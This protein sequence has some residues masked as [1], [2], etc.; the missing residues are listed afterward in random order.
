MTKIKIHMEWNQPN[1]KWL[2][3]IGSIFFFDFDDS[4]AVNKWFKG[5]CKE[6]PQV[7]TFESEPNGK[8]NVS[9]EWHR[10]IQKWSV[11]DIRS[12]PPEF[13][14]HFWNCGTFNKFFRGLSKETPTKYQLSITKENGE[15]RSSNSLY[16]IC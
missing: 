6:T 7:Y 9:I 13:L 14:H 16:K 12:N 15:K 8:G 4:Y 5:L 3:K 1:R 11:E 2:A 10:H